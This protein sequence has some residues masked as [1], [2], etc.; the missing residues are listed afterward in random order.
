MAATLTSDLDA[1]ETPGTGV[2]PLPVINPITVSMA[3]AIL[4]LVGV[5]AAV[6]VRPAAA[7]DTNG[8]DDDVPAVVTDAPAG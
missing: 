1:A 3:L 4:F 8:A 7:G 6:S 2:E 5:L